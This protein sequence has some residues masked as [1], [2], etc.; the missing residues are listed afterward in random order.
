MLTMGFDIA[1]FGLQT[2]AV[3]VAERLT[4]VIASA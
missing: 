1:D 4:F 3:A 2:P